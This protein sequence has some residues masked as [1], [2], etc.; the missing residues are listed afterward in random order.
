[1]G[2]KPVNGTPKR[3]RIVACFTD[4]E[5]EDI[6]RTA[7]IHGI[8]AGEFVA[9]AALSRAVPERLEAVFDSLKKQESPCKSGDG[10]RT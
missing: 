7:A 2:R 9:K 3:N 6:K 10:D 8:T 1:M 5:Y 4:S